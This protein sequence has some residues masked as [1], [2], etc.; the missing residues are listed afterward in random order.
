MVNTAIADLFGGG[1]KKKDAFIHSFIHSCSSSHGIGGALYLWKGNR[2]NMVLYHSYHS[3]VTQQQPWDG[4]SDGYS[5]A[6][7]GGA[8]SIWGGDGGVPGVPYALNFELMMN[9]EVL[10]E[11]VGGR[12]M[13]TE[14][15]KA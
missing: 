8:T 7:S 15:Q 9:D 14:R 11:R 6:Q 10:Y 12:L 5:E 3:F 2:N 4:R 1:W 13:L